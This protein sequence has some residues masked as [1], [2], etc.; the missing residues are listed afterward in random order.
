[1]TPL[2]RLFQVLLAL[3]L[4]TGH[5]AQALDELTISELSALDRQYMQQQRQQL[6]AL[7]A[8]HYGRQFTGDRDRDLALMQRLL[9]DGVVRGTQT[10]LLQG[11]GIL[12]GDLLAAELGLDWVVYE[13]RAG[14][15]RALRYRESDS[16]LFPVT[17]IS[18]RR[19]VG[20]TTSVSEIYSKAEATM[21]SAMPALPFQ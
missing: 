16:Y 3:A 19:E 17:M 18:R 1:M 14:R 10:E 5:P 2:H 7:S 8:R 13:D 4:V 20:N 21:R 15:S 6:N 9:D 12:L 11:M